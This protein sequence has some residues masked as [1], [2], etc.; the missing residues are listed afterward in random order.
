VNVTLGDPTVQT[1]RDLRKPAPLLPGVKWSN[2]CQN[3]FRNIG[4]CYQV[5]ARRAVEPDRCT[6][7]GPQIAA[8]AYMAAYIWTDR[9]LADRFA[10]PQNASFSSM[11]WIGT[12]GPYISAGVAA[13]VGAAGVWRAAQAHRL[14][15]QAEQR[16]ERIERRQT[17]R[18]DV[19][20][21][22][23]EWAPGYEWQLRN[24]GND[25]AHDVTLEIGT[26][27]SN[28]P[29]AVE[30][31]R[32]ADSGRVGPGE[33]IGVPIAVS[34][35]MMLNYYKNQLERRERAEGA[36]GVS[37]GPLSTPELT[38]RATVFCKTELGAVRTHEVAPQT[39]GY[40]F[41]ASERQPSW[42]PPDGPTWPPPVSAL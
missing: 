33:F 13:I 4:A 16:N 42:W 32:R 39:V 11:S 9:M 10:C 30:D 37:S 14:A 6:A 23:G 31:V 28:N 7:A 17:E 25:S 2:D 22:I 18:G 40:T 5:F 41:D 27:P 26:R 15:R 1:A 38:I 3:R 36:A 12:A 34:V 8:A 35:H 21:S 19:R 29:D 24:I 20:W